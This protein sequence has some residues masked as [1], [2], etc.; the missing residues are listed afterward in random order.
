MM[1]VL[2]QAGLPGLFFVAFLAATLLPL[3]SEIWVVTLQQQ[4]FA[5]LDLL[6]VAGAGNVLGSCVNYALGWYAGSWLI[7]KYLRVSVTQLELAQLRLQKHGY[8]LLLFAWLP[9]VGDPLTFMAGIL[10]LRFSVFL[11]LVGV[12]K[13]ARYAVLLYLFT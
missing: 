11:L 4:G 8:V 10:K 12:G 5:P 13:L 9:V 6:L 7:T 3:G 1:D 2:Q